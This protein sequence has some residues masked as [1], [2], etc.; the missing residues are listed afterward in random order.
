MSAFAKWL[1]LPLR[2]PMLPL[3]GFISFYLGVHWG[4]EQDQ[5]RAAS[6][7]GH[8]WDEVY[9]AFTVLQVLALVFFCTLPDLVL[10]QVSLFMAASKVLTLVITLLLVVV[11]GMYLLYMPGFIDLLVLACALLLARLDLVRAR[12]W[13]PSWLAMAGFTGY[14]LFCVFYGHALHHEMPAKVEAARDLLQ[15]LLPFSRR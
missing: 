3:L 9:W 12:I 13:P 8:Y 14:I 1:L 15:R 10:R 6:P 4:I 2:L 7:A 5:I 11:G